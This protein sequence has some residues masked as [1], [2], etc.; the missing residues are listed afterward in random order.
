MKSPLPRAVRWYLF[1][2]LLSACGPVAGDPSPLIRTELSDTAVEYAFGELAGPEELTTLA[3]IRG[4][5]LSGDGRLLAVLDRMPP[6]L[7]LIDLET[8]SAIAFGAGGRGP[9]ELNS[10]N[11]IDFAGDSLLVLSG[12]RIEYF[13]SRGEW[14]G[15]FSVA[16]VGIIPVSFTVAC[17]GQV[18]FYGPPRLFMDLAVVEWLHRLDDVTEPAATSV[19]TIPGKPTHVPMGAFRGVSGSR[20]GVFVWHPVL[21]AES[22]ESGYWV[23]CDREA[24]RPIDATVP[25]AQLEERHVVDG[26]RIASFAI[27]DTLFA[28]TGAFEHDVLRAFQWRD[29]GRPVTTFRMIRPDSCSALEV[30]GHY[31]V[32]SLSEQYLMLAVH[33]P[34]PQALVVARSWF[35]ARLRPVSC[36]LDS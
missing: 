2:G 6:H 3:R 11:K 20:R 4:M 22:F 5:A 32:F 29:Q 25:R 10:P 1:A 16:R 24:P 17:A 31:T 13:S 19:L 26:Q 33:D 14:I 18:Y 8:G 15:G 34:Y 12:N 28:G 36:F 35:T 30:E 9:G 27:P 7:R 21:A 23:P